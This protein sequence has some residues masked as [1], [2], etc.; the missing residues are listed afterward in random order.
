MQEPPCASPG[1]HPPSPEYPGPAGHEVRGTINSSKRA[2][3]SQWAVGLSLLSPSLR[4]PGP[5]GRPPHALI[6]LLSPSL[7]APPPSK[8]A[9]ASKRPLARQL[10]T[11][12]RHLAPVG[13]SERFHVSHWRYRCWGQHDNFAVTR[14]WRETSSR[15]P[16]TFLEP[17]VGMHLGRLLPPPPSLYCGVVDLTP[18]SELSWGQIDHLVTY[19][20]SGVSY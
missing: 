17:G 3:A 16:R 2:E 20:C 6:S 12:V 5:T 10:G 4:G 13:A 8:A 1:T 18:R 19:A 7:R 9:Q 15:A 11:C 14:P